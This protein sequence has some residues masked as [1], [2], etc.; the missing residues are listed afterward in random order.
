[1][2]SCTMRLTK[3]SVRLASASVKNLCGT[4]VTYGE[5]M[6]KLDAPTHRGIPS[7]VHGTT[8]DDHNSL[9]LFRMWYESH[10]LFLAIQDNDRGTHVIICRVH[11]FRDFESLELSIGFHDWR[12]G[13]RMIGG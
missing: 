10:D 9:H 6:Q 12:I 4:L 1:M 13:A 7:T 11:L 8:L 2:M 3:G 5:D